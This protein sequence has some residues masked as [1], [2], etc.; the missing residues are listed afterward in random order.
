MQLILNAQ[1]T[2]VLDG[3]MYAMIS[4]TVQVGLMKWTITVTE[5]VVLD[6]LD[7]MEGNTRQSIQT[8]ITNTESYPHATNIPASINIIKI[9]DMASSDGSAL[10]S[11]EDSPQMAQIVQREKINNC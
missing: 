8:M 9:P 6:I 10:V 7:V 3:N 2:T 1:D 11:D 5:Q 4:L